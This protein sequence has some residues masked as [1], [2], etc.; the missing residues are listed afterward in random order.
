MTIDERS[1]LILQAR[2]TVLT[3]P[4]ALPAID[5]VHPLIIESWRR[6]LMYGLDPDRCTPR[7]APC[8]ETTNQLR[9]VSAPIVEQRRSALAQSSCSLAITDASGRILNRW[10]EDNSFASLLDTK[11]VMPEYSVAEMTAGTTSGGIVLETGQP[12]I[13]AGPE[14]FSGDWMDMT[15][16]GAPIR[17]PITRRLIGSLNLTV[18]YTDTT[19]FLQ[20]WVTDLATE[21]ERALLDNA[22]RREQLL[23]AAYLAENRDT[24]HP[25]LCLDDQTVISNAPAARMLSSVDQALLWEHASNHLQ[26]PGRFKAAVTLSDGT[27]AGI[28]IT[29][30][31]DGTRAIGAV[32]RVR[33]D[34]TSR[35]TRVSATVP[36]SVALPG[37]VGRSEA[38]HR[39]AD[40]VHTN[41]SQSMLLIGEPGV[42]KFAVASAIADDKT[43]VVD[44]GVGA[45]APVEVWLSTVRHACSSGAPE[46]LLRHIDS[47]DDHAA[48]VAVEVL[49]DAR[50]RGVRISA[51]MTTGSTGVNRTPLFD[52]FDSVVKVPSLAERS[53][54]L[55]LLLDALTARHISGVRTV[56]WLPDAVQTLSRLHWARNVSSLNAV[57]REV[58]VNNRRPTIG[59]SDLPPELRAQ[60]GRR[61]LVGLEHVEAKAIMEALHNAR[62]NKRL[63][64]DA[65]G[66]ARSTLYRKVRAL[67]IDLSKANF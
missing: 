2:E 43:A 21:I 62:G 18:R 48:R 55:P 14:H 37:L 23:M 35:P 42:G 20:S 32:V 22:S 39:L 56:R 5:G 47:V 67:G 61:A 17:H 33:P 30:I 60:A 34:D 11:S 65:L 16:A 25:V 27:V 53:D 19:P 36:P 1:R 50:R 40:E 49:D 38:W 58:L 13:V 6:S 44:C 64:A 3:S 8:T 45:A 12:V 46:V 59:A 24:R 52:W 66:I 10:V 29:S 9:R 51:T 28:D 4:E 7:P 15:C 63:A 31:S 54:D 57:V 41:A 26:G